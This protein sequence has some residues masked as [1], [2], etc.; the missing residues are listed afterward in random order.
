MQRALHISEDTLK[1]PIC[2]EFKVKGKG[3]IIRKTMIICVMGTVNI[4]EQRRF[5]EWE[6]GEIHSHTGINR[7]GGRSLR[8][9]GN[10][11]WWLTTEKSPSW[12]GFEFKA[13]K[14]YHYPGINEL[15]SSSN[16][17]PQN[18]CSCVAGRHDTKTTNTLTHEKKKGNGKAEMNHFLASSVYRDVTISWKVVFCLMRLWNV[19]M[20]ETNWFRSYTGAIKTRALS[21]EQHIWNV[22]KLSCTQCRHS[23]KWFIQKHPPKFKV[24]LEK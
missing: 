11:W 15:P 14:L 7:V 9:P 4:P 22:F 12:V 1:H 24:K 6:S 20:N 21:H 23:T 18:N 5:T 3:Y 17:F 19:R 10:M 8:N 13:L 16:V 2:S